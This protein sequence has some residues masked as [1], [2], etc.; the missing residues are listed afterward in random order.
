ML[1]LTIQ[2]KG[3]KIILLCEKLNGNGWSNSVKL[4]NEKMIASF[5]N[6]TVNDWINAFYFEA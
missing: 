5:N 6:K 4:Y 1:I 3:I 2:L